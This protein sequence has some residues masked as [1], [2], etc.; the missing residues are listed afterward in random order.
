MGRS[1]LP[2]EPDVISVYIHSVR[3]EL[4][5]NACWCRAAAAPHPHPNAGIGSRDLFQ[6]D[7]EINT[8]VYVYV[9]LYTYISCLTLSTERA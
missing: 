8:D 9:R 2:V 6:I 4:I 5:S 7:T 1:P 3:T